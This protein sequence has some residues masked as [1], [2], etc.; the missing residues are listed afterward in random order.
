MFCFMGYASGFAVLSTQQIQLVLQ[1][2]YCV[3]RVQS[4]AE[5]SMATICC[6]IAGLYCD[7]DTHIVHTS[8][9]KFSVVMQLQD[10][11]YEYAGCICVHIS[12]LFFTL[13]KKS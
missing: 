11:T 10:L 6:K 3:Y 8:Q 5:T 4:L 13:V 9:T 12:R 1:K 2:S 7:T